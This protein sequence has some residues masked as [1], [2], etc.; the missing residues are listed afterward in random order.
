M[1]GTAPL[2][3]CRWPRKW[4]LGATFRSYWVRFNLLGGLG[5]FGLQ[6]VLLRL[7]Q[8]PIPPLVYHHLP[9]LSSLTPPPP[10]ASL[11][12]WLSLSF[13][14]SSSSSLPSSPC[15]PATS[16]RSCRLTSLPLD[17]ARELSLVVVVVVVVELDLQTT[18]KTSTPGG[19]LGLSSCRP[20]GPSGCLDPWIGETR[21]RGGDE[22]E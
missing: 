15:A 18:S 20:R 12:P 14:S 4:A 2:R 10:L 7:L 1:P 19:L 16:E 22:K 5:G 21:A 6:H 13:P 3:P 8:H 11:S 9:T 17:L